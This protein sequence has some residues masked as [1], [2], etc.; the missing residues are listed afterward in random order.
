[1]L[2]R[3]GYIE[4][5]PCWV[6]RSGSD[7]EAAARFYTEL[8]GWECENVSPAGD[9]AYY[10]ARIRGGD[11]AA[12]AAAD[13]PAP[14]GWNTY[15]WV[16]SVD[17]VCERVYSA[18]GRVV[19][20]PFDAG[21]AGRMAVFSDP[22]GAVF[23]VWQANR[24]RGARI[25]NEHGA[26]NFN[27]LHTRDLE[28]AKAFYGA[29][30]G[31]EL[32]PMGAA[33]GGWRC[34]GY[35]DHLEQLDPGV[36]ERMASVGAPAGFEDVVATVTPIG[37]DERDV[38][39]YWDVIFAADD[40]DAIAARATELGGKVEAGPFDAPWVRSVVI[41]DPGGALFTAN[42]FVL[43]NKDLAAPSEPTFNAA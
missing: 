39:P 43:Q 37:A 16:D 24:H 7:A 5:V 30:F 31:W 10:I 25:V 26:V 34:P 3:D 23:R 22:E 40:A 4:G 33:G 41:R 42:Q 36:R 29:V 14:A 18:G 13:S 6:D 35:G 17:E 27:G 11:V 15:I 28:G 32:L 9:P 20:E 38:Q 12:I 1:M 2:E 21:D 8:F 19:V